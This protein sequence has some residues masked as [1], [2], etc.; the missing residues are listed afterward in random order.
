MA[1]NGQVEIPLL[2]EAE[3]DQIMM[4]TVLP[5]L[6]QCKDE[7]W[8]E[9]AQAENLPVPPSEGSLHYVCYDFKRFEAGT[10]EKS[11][12]SKGFKGAIV[13]SH[14]FTEFAAKYSE[15]AW[16]FLQAGYSVCVFEHRGHGYSVR[17][18]DDP[19]LVHI[20]DWHR[21][22]EDLAKFAS[23]V[24]R[25]MADD[26]PLYLFSH[27][28]GG[29]IGAAVLEQHPTVFDKAVLSA[30]MI[31]PALGM[32]KWLAGFFGDIMSGLGFGERMV[33]AHESFT[34]EFDEALHVGASQP[35]V[36]WF[37]KLRT[38]N[39]RYQ[40][41]AATYEWARQSV[42]ISQYVMSE[43]ACQNITTPV[44]LCQAGH[45]IWVMN[46]A[47]DKFVQ[48]VRSAGGNITKLQFPESLHEIF[49]MPNETLRTYLDAVLAFYDEPIEE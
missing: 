5:A 31:E 16:Y 1:M 20:D 12:S 46:P 35:R 28:M 9:P 33:Y 11:P 38:E 36:R 39:E 30:P 27:S 49:S 25:H 4:Q 40:T 41:N 44:L 6:E 22:V 34:P 32:P 45:D 23:T 37:H 13:I 10:S 24:G 17:D 7:G 14:G 19:S 43:Q 29:G 21:Y 26:K 3:Y 8:M 48:R 47:Q 15:M 42:K 18:V 2:D